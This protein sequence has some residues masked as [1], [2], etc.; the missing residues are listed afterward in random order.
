M[1]AALTYDDGYRDGE[2]NRLADAQLFHEEVL[3][4]DTSC[5]CPLAAFLAHA[6]G[7]P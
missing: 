5:T 2:S 3:K 1:S 4:H 7:M 6:G